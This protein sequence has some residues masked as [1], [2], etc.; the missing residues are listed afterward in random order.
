LAHFELRKAARGV[1]PHRRWPSNGGNLTM[2][3]RGLP[4]LPRPRA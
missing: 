4:G 2:P 3:S 1:I